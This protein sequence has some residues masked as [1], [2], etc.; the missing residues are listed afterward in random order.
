MGQLL[1]PLCGYY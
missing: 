1:L